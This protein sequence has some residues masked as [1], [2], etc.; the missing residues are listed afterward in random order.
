MADC[1]K[2]IEQLFEY[3]D[4]ELPADEAAHVRR[5]LEGCGPCSGAER[6]DRS[7]IDCVRRKM[8]GPDVPQGLRDRVLAFL[9]DGPESG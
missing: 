9:P 4:R 8:E 5:H 2:V 6:I 3:I 7:F 1:E